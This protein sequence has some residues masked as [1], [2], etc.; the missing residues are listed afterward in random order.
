MKS[1]LKISKAKILNGAI[2]GREC[3]N[4]DVFGTMPNNEKDFTYFF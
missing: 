1:D 4:K 2:L 3:G